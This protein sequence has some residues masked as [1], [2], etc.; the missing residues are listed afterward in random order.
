[1][2]NMPRYNDADYNKEKR[3][4]GAER[5]ISIAGE[6]DAEHKGRSKSSDGRRVGNVRN[7]KWVG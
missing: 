7:T 5:P 2:N 6:N 3:R 1:M 4:R